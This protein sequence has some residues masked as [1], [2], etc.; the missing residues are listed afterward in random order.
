M[1]TTP[2]LR[3]PDR[4]AGP[5]ELT[6]HFAEVDGQVECV[7]VDIHALDNTPLTAAFV[8]SL[9]IGSMMSEALAATDDRPLKPERRSKRGRQSWPPERLEQVAEVYRRALN[10]KQ[11][12][13]RA[14]AKHFGV[15]SSMAAKLVHR[16]R[17]L[18]LLDPTQPGKAG[19]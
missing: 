5:W 6:F 19:G 10:L 17:G 7:G 11:P 13:T 14:V 9:P 3:H 4:S 2:Q 1:D 8:R 16:C 15:S 12:P 18:G